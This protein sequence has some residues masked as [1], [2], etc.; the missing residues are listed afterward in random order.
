MQQHNYAASNGNR[1]VAPATGIFTCVIQPQA[2][3]E[4]FGL[5]ASLVDVLV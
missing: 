2:N 4:G 5:S 1:Q 3:V